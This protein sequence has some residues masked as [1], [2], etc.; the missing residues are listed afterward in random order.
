MEYRIVVFTGSLSYAVRAGIAAIDEALPRPSWMIVV[1]Q[2]RKHVVTLMRNQ[3]RNL[4]RNGWRWIAYQLRELVAAAMP[5]ADSTA[6][7]GQPGYSA[8]R[9][10]LEANGRMIF[11]LVQ[12]LHAESTI[13]KV[14]EFAP[15]LGLSIAAPILRPALF[16]IPRLG[17]LNLHKGKVP[18]Y[19]GMPPAF[20]EFW[21]DEQ[22]VGCTVHEVDAKLDTGRVVAEKTV[23]R[24]RYSTIKGVQLTLDSIGIALMRDA[25]CA[26]LAGTAQRRAQ[27]PDGK[28][29]R[30]PTL[31]Q[32]A[33]LKARLAPRLTQRQRLMGLGKEVALAG[34]N[35][36][37]V[38]TR[39]SREP[40]VV[41]LLYHRV[42]DDSRDNLTVG[43]EQFDRQMA[44]LR[45]R[46]H[47]FA[48][49][50]IL[51]MPRVPRSNRPLVC[52]TFDD[53]YLDNYL[54]AAPI[55]ERHG[56]PAAFF[57]ATGMM[58]TD[59]PFPHDIRR[60]NARPQT[61]D[62][63]HVRSMRARG[64]TIGSHS[65]NHIDCAKE[66]EGVV[67]RELAQSMSDLRRELAT[68]EPLIFAYPY[69]GRE[70]MTSA[71]LE[72]V[73]RAGY[74][75]CLSAY[76]GA[77][78]GSVDPFAVL[79]CGIHCGFSDRAFFRRCLGSP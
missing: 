62:W 43:I 3:W 19:R 41:V 44:L 56:I 51:V 13:A 29:F 55:L 48:L 49:S 5:R 57:V 39:A 63:D 53:G 61:M 15:D 64:F 11:C 36:V 76:G 24:D 54:H 77:N 2:P 31:G 33:A 40:R 6:H 67:T 17:T 66:S 52:V 20:W 69:G 38:V 50:E 16:G 37:N 34:L 4:R 25:A 21:N 71:R 30:K 65:V 7:S 72:L 46:C 42:S 47:V 18:N 75:G 60:G 8:S 32:V 68:N 59:K 79:R 35:F 73:K 27:G 9:I 58:G 45:Q 12:N 74:A 28:T 1:E 78:I 10:A 22:Y 14:R 23:V 70:H 26:V